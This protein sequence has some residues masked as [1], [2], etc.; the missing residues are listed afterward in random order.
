MA[1]EFPS[2]QFGLQ[3][4]HLL[5]AFTRSGYKAALL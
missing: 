3:H 5:T 4:C 1:V 2:T